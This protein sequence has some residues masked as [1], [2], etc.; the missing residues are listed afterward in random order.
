LRRTAAVQLRLSRILRLR[1]IDFEAITCDSKLYDI[2]GAMRGLRSFDLVVTFGIWRLVTS[3]ILRSATLVGVPVIVCP[4]GMLEPWA[5]RQKA[6]KKRLAWHAYQ[7]SDL[8]HSVALHA[9]SRPEAEN[10]QQLGLKVPV[11]V[12]PHGI[13]LPDDVTLTGARRRREV[14]KLRTALFLSRLHPKKGVEDL[15]QAWAAVRP[16]GWELVIAG[17][18]C[19]GY[20]E[21]VRKRVDQLN[22]ATEVKLHGPVYGDKKSEMFARADLFVLPSYSENFGL[23]IPEALSYGVPV[24]ATTATPWAELVE[25]G[26]GWWVEPG[27]EGITRAIQMAVSIYPG[28]LAAMGERGRRMVEERYSW[29]V[30]IERHVVLY[31]WAAFGDGKPGFVQ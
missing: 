10:L 20:R 1:N 8:D 16:T 9:T 13:D 28:Q 26:C 23:V 21:T 17:P 22:C 14:K 19:D 29:S 30:L 12:L 15:V 4:M 31:R 24:I 27:I 2:Y 11:V 25:T 18:D 5:L 7:K 6:L 3:L